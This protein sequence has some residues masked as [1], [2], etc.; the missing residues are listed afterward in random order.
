[1]GANTRRPG[2]QVEPMQSSTALEHKAVFQGPTTALCDFP[3]WKSFTK[4]YILNI[5]KILEYPQL[6]KT[7][8]DH[9]VQLLGHLHLPLDA[10]KPLQE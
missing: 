4:R 5:K 10:A 9:Q 3:S 2:A 7:R 1:M 6:E 8:K